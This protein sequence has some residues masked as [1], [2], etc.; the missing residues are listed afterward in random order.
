[1]TQ[2]EQKKLEF[3][4]IREQRRRFEM[5]MQLLD[6][7]QRKEAQELAQMEAEIRLAGHQSEPTTPPEYVSNSTGFPSIFSR[8][9]QYSTSSIASP[10]GFSRP[11]RSG[12][13]LKHST[14][15][16][17][18]SQYGLNDRPMPS[19]SD[20]NTRRNSDDEDKEEAVRQDP[21]SHRSSN[22]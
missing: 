11:A 7:Q 18:Q 4:R 8:P 2:I 12:S 13:Q 6:Q 5:E 17:V 20:P 19:R 3:E 16:L 21:T 14:S 9:N 1:M 10:P 22:T 15:G